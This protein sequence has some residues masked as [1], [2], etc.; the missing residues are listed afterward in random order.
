MKTSKVINLHLPLPWHLDFLNASKR[1]VDS[2]SCHSL[3]ERYTRGFVNAK[4]IKK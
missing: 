4:Q 1:K 3:I 2:S